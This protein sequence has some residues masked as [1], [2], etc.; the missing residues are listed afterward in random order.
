ME[1]KNRTGNVDEFWEPAEPATAELK[2]KR[3]IFIGH[4]GV[5]KNN[6]DV[7]AF[8]EQVEAKHRNATHNCWAYC[9]S[10]DTEHCSD[11][12]EPSGTAGKPILHAIKQSG[13][14]NLMV[15][16]TRYYGGV[17]LGV[18]GLI[19]A[20]GQTAGEV[21]SKTRRV[22]RVSSRE[23][24]ICLPYSA[25]GDIVRLLEIYGTPDAPAWEY[26]AEAEVRAEIRLSM[27]PQAAAALQEL[28][29]KNLIF[30]WCWVEQ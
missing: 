2:I 18:R 10:A 27:A 12:G 19:E 20:Y 15:V 5:C 23:L 17:K 29:A 3:S 28:Q 7:R 1:E 6:E 14:V 24:A 25:T 4:L 26:G 13:M 9:F 11:D 16:V 30:S 22:L 8:L 21:I